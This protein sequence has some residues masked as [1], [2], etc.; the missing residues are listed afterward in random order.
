[1]IFNKIDPSS[2]RYR[3]LNDSRLNIFTS[4]RNSITEFSGSAVAFIHQDKFSNVALSR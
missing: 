1:M 2:D 3:H 4:K